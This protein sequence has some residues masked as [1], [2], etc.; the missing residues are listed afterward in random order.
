MPGFGFHRALTVHIIL[1]VPT[2][3]AEDHISLI[4]SRLLIRTDILR[5]SYRDADHPDIRH[6]CRPCQ[7]QPRLDHEVASLITTVYSALSDLGTVSAAEEPAPEPA[8]TVRSSIKKDHLVFLDCGKKM[9]MLRRH[10]STEHGMSP[11]EYREK[12]GLNAD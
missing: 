11:Q 6:C 3:D 4:G 5:R 10:L 8:V 12:W 1:E 2:A 9:K 7:H